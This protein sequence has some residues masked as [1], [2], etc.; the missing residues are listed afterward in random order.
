MYVRCCFLRLFMNMYEK[1]F[2]LSVYALSSSSFL[3]IVNNL[4]LFI[5]LHDV[6]LIKF[7]LIMRIN[8]YKLSR[9]Y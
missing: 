5:M 1:H 2:F 6:I 3:L 9:I 7:T 8:I 4:F